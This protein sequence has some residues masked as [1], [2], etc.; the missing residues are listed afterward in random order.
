MN[1]KHL[2]T[3]HKTRTKSCCYHCLKL[4]NAHEGL[5]CVQCKTDLSSK[6]FRNLSCYCGKECFRKD[7]GKHKELFH[8]DTCC[9]YP[10]SNTGMFLDYILD[11]DLL[12]LGC[13]A[14]GSLC[15]EEIGKCNDHHR[16]CRVVPKGS[17]AYAVYT[18]FK[19]AGHGAALPKDR[20][21]VAFPVFLDIAGIPTAVLDILMYDCEC[22]DENYWFELYLF[23]EKNDYST[24]KSIELLRERI[25]ELDAKYKKKHNN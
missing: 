15:M 13:R 8:D 17:G 21:T 20:T 5:S 25:K 1:H 9:Q 23:M 16:S 24:Q 3:V 22:H 11:A 18:K 7:W 14:D 19:Y 10:V 12:C 4:L 6:C 2:I